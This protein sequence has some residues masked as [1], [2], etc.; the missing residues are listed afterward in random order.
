[1]ADADACAWLVA[2]AILVSLLALLPLAF[3]IWIAVQTGWETVSALVF[4]PR[5]G[6]LLVNTVLL[7]RCAVPICHRAV[8]GAGLADRAQRPAR[9]PALGLAGGG[10]ARHAGFRAQLCLDHHGAR[11]CTACGPACWFP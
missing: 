10:A 4:R 1:M 3:I 8:G 9:R 11:A 6:E 5:V 2:A 7:V